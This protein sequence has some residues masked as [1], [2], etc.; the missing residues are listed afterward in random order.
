MWAKYLLPRCCMRRPLK[1]DIQH[2]YIPKD[3]DFLPRPSPPRGSDP[4]LQ[5]EI[6]FDMFHIYCSSDCMQ[7]LG[8]HIDN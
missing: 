1:F 8:K 7:N 6:L 2:D 3:N 5:T 4:V